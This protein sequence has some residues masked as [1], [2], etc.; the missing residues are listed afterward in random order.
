MMRV[1]LLVIVLLLAVGSA[2]GQ[3]PDDKLIVPGERIGS[4]R[5]TTK[6]ADVTSVYG[7]ETGR[8]EGIWQGSIGLEWAA[9]GLS[10]VADE[11]SGNLL[12][13]SIHSSESRRW[14]GFATREELALETA[15]Q[16]VIEAFGEPTRIEEGLTVF[17][18]SLRGSTIAPLQPRG[19]Y[20]NDRGIYFA[21]QPHGIV[22]SIVVQRPFRAPG[23]MLVVPGERISGVRVGMSRDEVF[24]LLGGGFV[25]YRPGEIYY[26]PHTGLYVHFRGAQVGS[27][28]A[29]TSK[30]SEWAG[31]K[32]ATNQGLGFNSTP[33]QVR[34]LLGEPQRKQSQGRYEAWTYL[35]LGVAFVFFPET[36]DKTVVIVGVGPK[37]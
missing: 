37:Q 3:T 30:L 2:T 13:I 4:L 9:I 11:R 32:Y 23:D 17:F 31:I 15:E 12:R 26:W 21:I 10:L 5:L 14:E 27:V 16:K 34:S 18:S 20:Y 33:D 28:E 25:E 35:S 29:T 8:G 24:N 19:L 36:P 7:R 1:F 6:L 22:K